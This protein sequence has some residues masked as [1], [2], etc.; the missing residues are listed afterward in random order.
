MCVATAA[1]AIIWVTFNFFQTPSLPKP[2]HGRGE[3]ARQG[4]LL[5]QHGHPLEGEHKLSKY[6]QMVCIVWVTLHR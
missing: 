1:K 4:I 3:S 5:C 2:K 6:S